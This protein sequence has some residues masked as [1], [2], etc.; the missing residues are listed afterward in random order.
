MN[1][2]DSGTFKTW[3]NYNSTRSAKE[4]ISGFE[5]IPTGV[6]HLHLEKRRVLEFNGSKETYQSPGKKAKL[7]TVAAAKQGTGSRRTCPA[8]PELLTLPGRPGSTSSSSPGRGRGT[9]GGGTWTPASKICM[10]RS[11]GQPTSGGDLSSSSLATGG[12]KDTMWTSSEKGAWGG[13][14]VEEAPA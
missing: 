3:I 7:D 14:G 11:L 4:L 12:R 10:P 9:P 1:E 13:W 6:S 8:R 2:H 5:N